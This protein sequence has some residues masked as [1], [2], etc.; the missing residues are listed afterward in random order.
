MKVSKIIADE[1]TELLDIKRQIY[2]AAKNEILLPPIK[3]LYFS[4]R[5]VCIRDDI[6]KEYGKYDALVKNNRSAHFVTLQ[7]ESEKKGI[8]F[9]KGIAEITSEGLVAEE[10]ISRNYF[11]AVLNTIDKQLKVLDTHLEI[12]RQ[13]VHITK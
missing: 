12:F 8:K 13:E 7:V 10:R 1:I 6:A 2:E 9:E 11:E 4:E 5:I 3:Y